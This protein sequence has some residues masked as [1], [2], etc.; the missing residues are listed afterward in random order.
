MQVAVSRQ[1]SPQAE[2]HRAL[3]SLAELFPPQHVEGLHPG[4]LCY[5][6]LGTFSQP[7]PWISFGYCKGSTKEHK[8]ILACL[9]N[10][11]LTCHSVSHH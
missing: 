4:L 5:F 6:P 8:G 10:L 1:P 7:L 2:Q 9:G 11:W 3:R